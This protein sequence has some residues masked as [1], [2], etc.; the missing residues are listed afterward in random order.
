MNI[1]ENGTAKKCPSN[2]ENY[3]WLTL[4]AVAL[5]VAIACINL[6]M[7]PIFEYLIPP[8]YAGHNAGEELFRTGST[9]GIFIMGGFF[10][11]L[12]E[13]I[14]AQTIPIEIL[15]RLKFPSWFSAFVS[16]MYFSFGHYRN[17]GLMHAATSMV[18]GAFFSG[19]Y[20]HFRSCSMRRAYYVTA[21]TH[22]TNNVFL[23]ILSM[24]E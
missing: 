8:R 17:G 4:R 10:I 16:T 9:A 15:R 14:I 7:S 6:A 3:C 1:L 22:C 24:L 11:P 21:M 12:F 18:A 20:I 23:F 19:I 2:S 5:G 13:T